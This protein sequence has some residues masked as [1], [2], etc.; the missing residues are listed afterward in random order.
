MKS[1][2]AQLQPIYRSVQPV[3]RHHMFIVILTSLGFLIFTVY[4]IN[5]ILQQPEDQEYRMAEEAK[6]SQT[7]FD[8]GTID[9]IKKLQSSESS[10]GIDLGKRSRMSPFVE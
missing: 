9:R 1:I 3:L 5:N 8:Q 4:S 2:S 10:D 7:K 6:Q